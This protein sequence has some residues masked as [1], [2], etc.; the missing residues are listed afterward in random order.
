MK[1][2]LNLKTE[3]GLDA[4][5]K[6]KQLLIRNPPKKTEKPKPRPRSERMKVL[7]GEEE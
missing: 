4:L 2:W 7:L 1:G 3:A 5:E 6:L